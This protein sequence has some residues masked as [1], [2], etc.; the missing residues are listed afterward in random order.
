[1]TSSLVAAFCLSSINSKSISKINT[2]DYQIADWFVRACRGAIFVI[3]IALPVTQIAML[4][5]KGAPDRVELRIWQVNLVTLI[6]AAALILDD[7]LGGF[8]MQY[9]Y[10]YV[11]LL[12][13]I[14]VSLAAL[15]AEKPSSMA[16]FAF[17]VGAYV[18]IS[19]LAVL[20]TIEQIAEVFA[21]PDNGFFSLGIVGLITSVIAT[22]AFVHKP[23][24]SGLALAV[25]LILVGCLGSPCGRSVWG[26][27]SGSRA[28]ATR[29]PTARTTMCGLGR[30]CSFLLHIGSHRGRH[31]G[32][33]SMTGI[34]RL[35]RPRDHTITV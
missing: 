12:P 35:S 15:Y 18:F 33:R 4:A 20:P 22:A 11:L 16:S 13:H 29:R 7:R 1:M 25:A 10:Y 21:S 17:L 3:A 26:V 6:I 23:W 34:G 19:A 14:A 31:F 9:D 2:V 24:P 28:P 30:P 5:E 8:F 32:C 27:S